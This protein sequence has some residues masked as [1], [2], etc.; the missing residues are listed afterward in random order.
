MAKPKAISHEET[1]MLWSCIMMLLSKAESDLGFWEDLKLKSEA[2][3]VVNT[4]VKDL[5]LPMI[6]E[7][8]S[9][10]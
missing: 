1:K 4:W 9:N 7:S 3:E 6:R 8:G 10:M 2:R 5:G